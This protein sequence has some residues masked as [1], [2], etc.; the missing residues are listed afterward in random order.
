[1]IDS[2]QGF[3]LAG[4]GSTR[5]GSDKGLALYR[6]R[7]LIQWSLA[8]LRTLDLT[9][10][11][12]TRSPS[13]YRGLATAFVTGESPGQGPVAG[14]RAALGA[15]SFPWSL[16]LSVDMPG[17]NA[18]L[19]EI[20]ARGRGEA[21]RQAGRNRPVVFAIGDRLHPFPGL[22]PGTLV[23]DVFE[24]LDSG[25]SMYRLLEMAGAVKLGVDRLP[26]GS[27]PA[28]IFRNVNRPEDLQN[29][30]ETA[31]ESD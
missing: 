30:L 16:V 4:G 25:A 27:D 11:V 29:P 14:L 1:M 18:R 3:V 20:L 2:T 22:Y 21:G 7:P 9:P 13:A 15:T 28:R 26:E 10:R 8:A 19:L 23:Q 24:S 31:P 12:V 6:G 5:F 17:A